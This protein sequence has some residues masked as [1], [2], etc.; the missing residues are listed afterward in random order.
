MNEKEKELRRIVET[1]VGCCGTV[2]CGVTI[3]EV[4]GKAR[5]ENVVMTRCILAAEIVR[6]GYSV[7]TASFLLGRSAQAIRQMIAND[8]RYKNT[9]RAYRIA[10][11]E[12]ARQLSLSSG[13]GREDIISSEVSSTSGCTFSP[14]AF[15]HGVSSSI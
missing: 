14:C 11:A 13:E 2:E 10:K 12:V 5:T 7:T 3:E 15:S 6:Q 9:S 1:V 8:N 4:L